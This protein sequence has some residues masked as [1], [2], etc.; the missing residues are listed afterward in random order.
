MY[1]KGRLWEAAVFTVAG[2]GRFFGLSLCFLLRWGRAFSTR[3]RL[4][5]LVAAAPRF[6]LTFP[7]LLLEEETLFLEGGMAVVG[8]D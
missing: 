1:G 3:A 6:T 5:E 2:L 7:P 4:E 8:N